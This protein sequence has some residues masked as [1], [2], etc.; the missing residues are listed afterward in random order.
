MYDCQRD[1][2]LH[3]DQMTHFT[4]I[5]H[6]TVVNHALNPYST[7]SYKRPHKDKCKTIE[8]KKLLY[9]FIHTLNRGQL[10]F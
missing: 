10:G 7:I 6:R 3:R 5:G 8:T 2:S 9:K 1:N 4:N